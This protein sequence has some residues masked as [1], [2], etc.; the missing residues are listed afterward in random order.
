MMRRICLLFVVVISASTTSA[1]AGCYSV[2]HSTC[3]KLD[4]NLEVLE[5]GECATHECAH[6]DSASFEFIYKGE[7]HYIQLV[8]GN[9]AFDRPILDGE[10]VS[11]SYAKVAHSSVP[12]E[13][14]DDIFTI[15]RP[16]GESWIIHRHVGQHTEE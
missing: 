14:E 4:K 12:Y 5:A 15:M 2:V 16:N 11:M 9:V 13:D 8:E 6:F 1:S 7:S 3:I 10:P